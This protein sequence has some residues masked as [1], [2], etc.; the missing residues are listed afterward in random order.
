MVSHPASSLV[1]SESDEDED[2]SASLQLMSS[3]PG[4]PPLP[5]LPLPLP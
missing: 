2:A 3:V 4:V 1:R 5:E